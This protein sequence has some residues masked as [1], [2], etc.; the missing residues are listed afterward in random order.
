MLE[1]HLQLGWN[2][3][4]SGV[5]SSS[6]CS[7]LYP[8]HYF[9]LNRF[10]GRMW[11]AGASHSAPDQS[12]CLLL[13]A[14]ARHGQAAGLGR[15]DVFWQLTETG[16]AGQKQP[17]KGT[18]STSI[19]KQDRHHHGLPEGSIFWCSKQARQIQNP[20]SFFHQFN[21]DPWLL[22]TTSCLIRHRSLA[23]TA[24]GHMSLSEQFSLNPVRFWVEHLH[25]LCGTLSTAS[26]IINTIHL[27]CVPHLCLPASATER[28]PC[29]SFSPWWYKEAR[30]LFTKTSQFSYCRWATDVLPCISTG[31]SLN[32]VVQFPESCWNLRRQQGEKKQVGTKD[33]C[34]HRLKFAHVK[35]QDIKCG[36][37]HWKGCSSATM[38]L[39]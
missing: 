9:S 8:I 18:I 38:I 32:K 35:A 23:D 25:Q 28:W 2:H 6:S 11:A 26:H 27:S 14:A 12:C 4:D 34:Y 15:G 21:F 20:P 31:R 1:S 3:L 36:L 24:W 7:R 22:I 17:L 16:S 37:R 29:S 10:A 30:Q 13:Q 5:S 33:K 39:H 19:S